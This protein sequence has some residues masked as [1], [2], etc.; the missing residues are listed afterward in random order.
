MY[1]YLNVGRISC[2][3]LLRVTTKF[4]R[5]AKRGS[6][7]CVDSGILRYL[8]EHS[9]ANPQSAAAA[10]GLTSNEARI[11]LSSN[12]SP[13]IP[14]T[15]LPTPLSVSKSGAWVSKERRRSVLG[16]VILGSTTVSSNQGK[17]GESFF[18]IWRYLFH[19]AQKV[20][21]QIVTRLC[22]CCPR[23]FSPSPI[24]LWPI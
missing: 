8:S 17:K 9:R 15:T 13:K 23:C 24:L 19:P 3:L 1:L 21:S 11:S 16:A 4:R 22:C 10:I 2:G 20:S 12:K 5:S 18:Q 6:G 7:S 14:S